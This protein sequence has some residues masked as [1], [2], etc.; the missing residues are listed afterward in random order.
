[1]LDSVISVDQSAIKLGFSTERGAVYKGDCMAL[2][3]SIRIL[4]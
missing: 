3:A 2:F 1:M 4:G